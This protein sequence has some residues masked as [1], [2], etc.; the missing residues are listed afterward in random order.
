MRL[1]KFTAHGEPISQGSVK[2]FAVGGRA[3]IVSK[4]NDLTAWRETVRHAAS[5]AMGEDW[6]MQMG[7]AFVKLRFYLPRPS[8]AP[9]TIDT[10]PITGRDLDKLDRAV[11]D[12]I[13]NAGAWK[14]DN[15]VVD[16]DTRKRYCVTPDLARIYNPKK[17][18]LT[19]RVEVEVRWLDG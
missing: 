6:E 4:S 5:L 9:K 16:L 11:L 8:G 12:A 17:H 3:R 19:P 7:A 14:D 15:R 18:R 10:Y 2:A 1:L 13:T